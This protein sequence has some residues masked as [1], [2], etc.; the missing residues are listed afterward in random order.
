MQEEKSSVKRPVLLLDMDEVLCQ[1]WEP[2]V[3]KCNRSVTDVTTWETPEW[4][5][6]AFNEAMTYAHYI[7]L[8][9][10]PGAVSAVK[11]LCDKWD[12][13][14][15]THTPAAKFNQNLLQAKRQWLANHGLLTLVKGF[16]ATEA[17][18]LVM[19]DVLVDDRIENCDKFHGPNRNAVLFRRPWSNIPFSHTY[20]VADGWDDVLSHLADLHARLT[21]PAAKEVRPD[22]T[23]LDAEFSELMALVGTYG[24]QKY[25][26]TQRHETSGQKNLESLLRHVNELQRGEVTNTRDW[27]LPVEAHIA[28]RAQMAWE[29]RMHENRT[30]AAED[31]EYAFDHDDRC[32]VCKAHHKNEVCW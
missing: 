7:G 6:S 10:M 23:Q 29:I 20:F 17:K 4:A 1:F 14:V 24:R 25:P 19:G 32:I 28:Y 2:I 12:V 3:R 5:R 16:F 13:Y 18:H 26:D 11:H 30:E 21:T 9:E 8:E 22:F 15:V 27:G 31:K